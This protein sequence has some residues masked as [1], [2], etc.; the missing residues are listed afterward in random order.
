MKKVILAGMS[1]SLLAG[2]ILT[3]CSDTQT[4]VKEESS[5]P[6]SSVRISAENSSEQM[7]PVSSET[8][9]SEVVSAE[10]VTSSN[11]PVSSE[12]PPYIPQPKNPST[13]SET[14]ENQIKTDWVSGY[15]NPEP[16]H[17]ADK[18]KINYYGTYNGHIAL[19]ISDNFY[20]Y[21]AVVW[22]DNIA[23]V[24]FH[25]LHDRGILIWSKGNFLDLKS[26]YEQ[27]LL[28]QTDLKDIE[29]FYRTN[30]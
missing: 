16:E 29:Y 23:G 25:D 4:A 19:M 20:S 6:A 30:Q 26:A 1:I 24:I 28:T 17:T 9:S 21:P 12:E 2:M 5:I 3:A 13:L 22:D 18:V 15:V 7:T 27:G 8:N 14:Q 11:T 10:Q